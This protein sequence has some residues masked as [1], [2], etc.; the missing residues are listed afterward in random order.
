MERKPK[1]SVCIPSYNLADVV[2]ETVRSVLGQTFTDFELLIEDDGSTDESVKVLAGIEDP[3]ITLVAKEKNEGQNCTTNNLVSRASGEYVA[4]LA[5]DDVW[6]PEKLAK[7]VAYLDSHP[8]C[9]IVF[10]YPDFIDHDGNETRY[11][12]DSV[13][14]LENHPKEWWRTRFLVGNTLF[15]STSLYRR[16]LHDVLGNFDESLHILADLDWYMRVVKDNELHI[17]PE[18]L[19]KIRMRR[20]LANLSAPRP[21]VREKHADEIK[22]FRERY[23]PLMV[24][25][26]KYL[27]ATPFYE[28]KG[29]SPYIRSL[30]HCIYG[31]AKFTKFD[32]EYLE[33]AGDSY[34]WRA[35]NKIADYFLK[36]D[37]S[38]L[39][40]I[41]SDHGWDVE[42]FFRVLKADVPIVGAAYPVKNNWEHYGVQIK[43]VGKEAYPDVTKDGLIRATKVPTG[44][45]KIE[46]RVFE[47][48][49][50]SEPENWYWEPDEYGTM[51]KMHNFFG[52]IL[53]DH[54]V[55][56]EDISFCRR[57]QRIGGELFVEPRVTIEHWGVK[58]WTGNYYH[59][60]TR[61]PGGSASE[62]PVPPEMRAA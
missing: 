40:F 54:V 3:R 17:I 7:Q 31:L 25:K 55:Y 39:F 41:D 26:Q 36:S 22:K 50:R 51:T 29:Y 52:H 35:R 53:E 16:A 27:V 12:D 9:G 23:R 19:A 49:K 21:D 61:Q 43:T 6:H 48:I 14:K 33:V 56:G 59:F 15:V 30:A 34:V 46:R 38:H 2:E 62:N 44:F 4:L 45:M 37:S 18:R 42:G 1:V 58:S 8:E 13:Q 20:G 28:V 10:G 60:L 47:E 57:W 11:L 5:A 32:F 24:K